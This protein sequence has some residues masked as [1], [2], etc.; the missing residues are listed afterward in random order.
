MKRYE[1]TNFQWVR[2]PSGALKS[3]VLNTALFLFVNFVVK[4]SSE[5]ANIAFIN[6]NNRKQMLVGMTSVIKF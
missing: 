2:L 6:A 1:I 5:Y 3:A 4:S